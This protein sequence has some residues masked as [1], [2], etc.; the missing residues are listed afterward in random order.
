M[1]L[2]QNRTRAKHERHGDEEGSVNRYSK[3]Q[4]DGNVD[5]RN[6]CNKREIK[7]AEMTSYWKPNSRKRYVDNDS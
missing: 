7:A 5:N 2:I 4:I 3:K 6:N 1:E